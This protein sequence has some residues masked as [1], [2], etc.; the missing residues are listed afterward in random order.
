M[1][2]ENMVAQGR[3]WHYSSS[4]C[5]RTAHALARRQQFSTFHRQENLMLKTSG[6]AAYDAQS[7]L[8]P[9]SFER[10]EPNPDDVQIEIL[11]CGVCHSDL[12]QV[13]NEWQNSTYPLV[14]G[15]EIIG[16][17]TRV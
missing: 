8:A 11:Y 12:H 14:P 9:F 15:H 10:R 5:R 4:L 2:D 6:Y 17:V 7:P 16:R 13:R 1:T 3:Q